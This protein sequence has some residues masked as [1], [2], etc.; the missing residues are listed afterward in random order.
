MLV[1]NRRLCRL[2][3]LPDSE[4]IVI[5][6]RDPKWNEDMSEA[7]N[8]IKDARIRQREAYRGMMSLKENGANVDDRIQQLRA[9]IDRE[10]ERISYYNGLCALIE[11]RQWPIHRRRPPA[12]TFPPPKET[13]R[14]SKMI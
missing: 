12:P 5:D 10:D 8:E 13:T 3:N 14:L 4:K 9:E 11:S 6:E 1:Y 7:R 2:F